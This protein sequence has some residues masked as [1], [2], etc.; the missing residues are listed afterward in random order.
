MV[1]FDVF[2]GNIEFSVT[3]E[4]LVTVFSEVGRV[5]DIRMKQEGGR[6]AG[7]QLYNFLVAAA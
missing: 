5:L 4:L 2:V 7:H 3:D 6:P 1:K